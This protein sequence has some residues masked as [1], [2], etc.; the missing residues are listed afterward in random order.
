[1]RLVA[2]D[3]RWKCVSDDLIY[4]ASIS[5]CSSK[6]DC[7][8]G[9]LSVSATVGIS[10]THRNDEPL[11]PHFHLGIVMVN[12]GMLR[13]F[14]VRMRVPTSAFMYM[15]LGRGFGLQGFTAYVVRRR[16]SQS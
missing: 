5:R 3:L 10:A 8:S 2:R 7:V 4:H 16:P 13:S 6:F 15:N 9:A 1:M 12:S 11:P 14:T